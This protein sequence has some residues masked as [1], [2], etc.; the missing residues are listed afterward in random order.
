[1]DDN[2]RATSWINATD[3]DDPNMSV[4]KGKGMKA[5]LKTIEID[6]IWWTSQ[7]LPLDYGQGNNNDP[8]WNSH[9]K[10]SQ[11]QLDE[12]GVKIPRY[13]Y[14]KSIGGPSYISEGFDGVCYNA[15]NHGVKMWGIYKPNPIPK[16]EDT[17]L[18]KE[19]NE[20]E[21]TDTIVG[22]GKDSTNDPNAHGMLVFWD[23]QKPK[24]W[25]EPIYNQFITKMVIFMATDGIV[26]TL[27]NGKQKVHNVV[28]GRN[29]LIVNEW[30]G[31]TS[32]QVGIRIVEGTLKVNKSR[33]NPTSNV[34]VYFNEAFAQNRVE[35]WDIGW[36]IY[37]NNYDDLVREETYK[38]RIPN[39][40]HVMQLIGQAPDVHSDIYF[41]L[42][43]FL[44]VTPQEANKISNKIVQTGSNTSG[45]TLYP[46]GSKGQTAEEAW[47]SYGQLSQFRTGE[48]A[49][50]LYDTIARFNLATT[51]DGI[52]NKLIFNKSSHSC[53]IRFCNVKTDAELGYSFYIDEQKD[54]VLMLPYN[55][56]SEIIEYL[57]YNKCYKNDGT[58]GS[59]DNFQPFWQ[60]GLKMDITNAKALNVQF[61]TNGESSYIHLF[62]ENM[63][64]IEPLIVHPQG[65]AFYDQRISLENIPI[66]A[67]YIVIHNNP[68][69]YYEAN[70]EYDDYS[71]RPIKQ[72]RHGLER[73][74]ALRYTNR[75][76]MKVLKSWSGI[77]EEAENIKNNILNL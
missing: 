69:Q 67:K 25:W 18:I 73:G 70:L 46:V 9:F 68:G 60:I 52:E 19:A 74:I 36:G 44:N 24:A 59:G 28:P 71:N 56:S 7:S 6:E 49:L 31:G 72:L 48:N 77:Q 41:R 54:E 13:D 50:W 22:K 23:Y 37:T 2:H 11:E 20:S 62:D 33:K 34:G 64:F 3:W 17:Q 55:A 30:S 40:E 38:W 39:N 27:T 32:A 75:E 21:L 57:P 35:N 5:D 53:P 47:Y 51:N 58:L 8:N 15:N 12:F 76:H 26:H 45:F 29:E 61:N 66:N 42:K 1:M 16:P 63:V 14:L 43:D 4:N 65:V 10:L